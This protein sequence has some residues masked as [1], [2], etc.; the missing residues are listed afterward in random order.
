MEKQ[1][2]KMTAP[3]MVETIGLVASIEAV[4][5][6]AKVAHVRIACREEIGGDMQRN[7]ARGRCRPGIGRAGIAAAEGRAIDYGHVIARPHRLTENH[8][9][10]ESKVGQWR[11]TE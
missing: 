7:G 9:N 8:S 2:V 5:A 4:D 3:G 11:L 6:M 10:G 1:H